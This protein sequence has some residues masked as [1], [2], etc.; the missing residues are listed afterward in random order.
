MTVRWFRER[1]DGSATIAV[2]Q[3]KNGVWWTAGY[4]SGAAQGERPISGNLE[5]YIARLQDNFNECDENGT[6]L[7]PPVVPR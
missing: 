3:G 5:E 7:V 1:T 2:W 4:L 6:V